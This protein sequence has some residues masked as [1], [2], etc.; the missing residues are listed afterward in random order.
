VTATLPRPYEVVARNTATASDNKI[1]DDTVAR[2]YGFA[3]GLV[4]GVDVY[5]YL[6]HP[7]VEAW[8]LEWLGRGRIHARFVHPV[9][10][11]HATTVAVD[12]TEGESD[13]VELRVVDDTGTTCATAE[14]SLDHDGVGPPDPDS[15]PTRPAPAADARPPASLAT[16]ARIAADD[17]LGAVAVTFRADEATGY[18]AAIGETL[19]TYQRERVA[20]PG[21]LLRLANRILAD[22]VCLGPWI[23]VESDVTLLGLVH[24]GDPVEARGRVLDAFER[25]GHD[26][27]VLDVVVLAAGLP[28]QRVRHTAIIRPREQDGV[29][30]SG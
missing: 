26:F 13:A 5:A 11:G 8:G 29:A 9:Y 16:L 4:P 23:H 2:R 27:V 20:H 28:V 1:H 22:N 19:S 21:W 6:T 12:P 7:L 15:F 25:K 14:G 10:D 3:G 24:D 30:V 18:L 17:A